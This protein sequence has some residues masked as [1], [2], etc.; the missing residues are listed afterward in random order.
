MTNIY[1]PNKITDNYLAEMLRSPQFLKDIEQVLASDCLRK[2]HVSKV[3]QLVKNLSQYR[4]VKSIILEN[5]EEITKICSELADAF[6][7]AS[8]AK[9]IETVKAKVEQAKKSLE[10]SHQSVII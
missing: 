6:S 10:T 8:F 1:Y 5:E 2:A 7:L 9:A 3:T 4:S